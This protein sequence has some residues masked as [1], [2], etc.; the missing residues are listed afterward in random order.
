MIR[1]PKLQ[2]ILKGVVQAEIKEHW[3]ETQIH[4][5]NTLKGNYIKK[6]YKAKEKNTLGGK[7][8]RSGPRGRQVCEEWLNVVAE[9]SVSEGKQ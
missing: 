7:V 2:E 8:N 1:K 5:K 3:T 4:I 9:N 6:I